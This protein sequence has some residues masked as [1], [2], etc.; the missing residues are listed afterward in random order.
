MFYVND[1]SLKIEAH[2]R[3]YGSRFSDVLVDSALRPGLCTKH[4]DN[5]KMGFF[6]LGAAW[7]TWHFV[8]R[9]AG[10]G[11]PWAR[12]CAAGGACAVARG[13]ER[14]GASFLVTVLLP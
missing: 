12:S 6:M 3:F 10:L 13:G 8:H 9:G 4:T 2:V 11:S 1:V 5:M 7:G 14:I